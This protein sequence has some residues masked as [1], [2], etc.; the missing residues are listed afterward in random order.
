MIAEHGLTTEQRRVADQ[1]LV[2]EGERR[3]H[4]VVALSGAHAY[5]FPSPD[6]DLDLKAV[7]VAPA[8]RLLGLQRVEPTAERME[9]I[10]GV[11]IDYSSNEILPVLQ[12]VLAGNGNFIERILGA[13][14]LEKSAELADLAP[15]V[16][17]ALTKRVYRHY[18]GFATSQRREM[19]KTPAPAAKRV[20]YVLRTALTGAHL[21]DT[22]RVVADLSLLIDDYG[23]GEARALIDQKRKGERTP[24]DAGAVERWRGAVDRAFETLDRSFARS[25]LPEAA[26]GAELEAWL[27]ELRRRSW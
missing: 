24:L 26:E 10:D 1:V 13:R 21:L 22:G 2:Q 27:L 18:Q 16:Q 5:G 23:F 25:T 11:E 19:E 9:V 4:L 15:L 3:R 6:S 14:L 8:S 20:L 17:R 7:H 12:G